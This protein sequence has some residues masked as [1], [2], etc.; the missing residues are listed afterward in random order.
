[1]RFCAPVASDLIASVQRPAGPSEVMKLRPYQS[2]TSP[3][4]SSC[5]D[6]STDCSSRPGAF[7]SPLMSDDNDA[8]YS[9]RVRRPARATSNALQ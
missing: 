8:R 2:S 1:V 3:S 6:C 9:S 7:C 4:S 5:V